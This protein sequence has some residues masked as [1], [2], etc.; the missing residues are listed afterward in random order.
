[1]NKISKNIIECLLGSLVVLIFGPLLSPATNPW[2]EIYLQPL[3]WL[4]GVIGSIVISSVIVYFLNINPRKFYHI[5]NVVPV[6]IF[7][8]ISVLSLIASFVVIAVIENVAIKIVLLLVVTILYLFLIY[9][10]LHRGVCIYKN[11]KIRIFRFKIKTYDA[12]KIDDIIFEYANK[13][14]NIIIVINGFKEEFKLS[15]FSA[16]MIENRLK[17]LMS[18]FD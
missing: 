1:M 11:G 3:Y 12:S 18:K 15:L 13:K 16:K 4:F 2:Y 10:F 17:R 9:I 8:T 14:C 5:V 6:S 7:W